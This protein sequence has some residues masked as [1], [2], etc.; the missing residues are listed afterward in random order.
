MAEPIF[1]TALSIINNARERNL[2]L[3]L[4]GSNAFRL[5]CPEF[6]HLFSAMNRQLTDVDLA[7]LSEHWSSITRLCE[8]MGFI[9]DR[10]HAMHYP[11]RLLFTIPSN[12]LHVDVF[13]D[14]LSYCHT[15]D[16]RERLKYDNPTIPLADLLLEKMQ[17]VQINEKDIIDTIVLLREHEL[18]AGDADERVNIS[19]ISDLLSKDWGFCYTV[20]RNLELTSSFLAKYPALTQEDVSKVRTRIAELINRIES[21]PKSTAWKLRARIGVRRRWYRE[22][23]ESP[24]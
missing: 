24:F 8:D 17:I 10:R 3:R 1:D 13:L 9:F 15:I 4:I 22:V 12:G 20:T 18:G 11:D 14:R 19:Y 23:D 6:R 16:L 5:H 7:G 21:H 2:E